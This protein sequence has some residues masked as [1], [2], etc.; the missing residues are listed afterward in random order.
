MLQCALPGS[1]ALASG[2]SATFEIKGTV[3]SDAEAGAV[4]VSE[5]ELTYANDPF[6]PDFPLRDGTEVEVT[7]NP[8]PA[9]PTF[10]G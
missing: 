4:I 7:G 5:V 2:A 8:T 1:E 6:G 9:E 3:A 10:T